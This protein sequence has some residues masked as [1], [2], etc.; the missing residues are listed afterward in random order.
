MKNFKKFA[1]KNGIEYSVENGVIIVV[2]EDVNLSSYNH[3]LP[4][5]IQFNCGGDVNLYS[6]N[7][8]LPENIQ[9]NCGGSVDLYSYNHPLPENIQFNCGGG[10]YLDSY[11]HPLPENIQF[12]CGGCV[13]LDSYNHPLP[14]NIQFNCGGGVW[15][16]SYNHPL[17]ENI[18]FNCG[19]SVWLSSYNHPLPENIQFNCGGSVWLS[20]YNHPLPENIQFNCG[21]DVNLP[22]KK[23]NIGKSFIERFKVEERE[24]KVVLYKRVSFDYK[25]QEDTPNETLWKIGSVVE[26]PNW[27]PTENECGEGKF[28]ACAKIHWCDCF[29]NK[30]D[31]KYIAILVEKNDLYEWKNNPAFPAKIAFRKCTVINEINKY[32]VNLLNKKNNYIYKKKK[33]KSNDNILFAFVVVSFVISLALILT[34]LG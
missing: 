2:G 5:N 19:G 3:P 14:E 34:Y 7:H 4:E 1:K 23:L 24:G 17:P 29:R 12:N 18:Q 11:N 8:S 33:E 30:K 9:F 21:G 27:N 32:Y 6:H 13:W 28:H 22:D 20:S 15:L 31:D 25:T 26:H 10:V 16:D